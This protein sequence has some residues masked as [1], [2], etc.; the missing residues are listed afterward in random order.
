MLYID[1]VTFE[2]EILIPVHQI[3]VQNT[4]QKVSFS[5]SI[6]NTSIKNLLIQALRNVLFIDQRVQ[7]IG[8]HNGFCIFQSLSCE[9]TVPTYLLE[10]LKKHKRCLQK[11]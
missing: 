6:K 5:Q 2:N 3:F 7:T 11:P 9:N 1:T 10:E 8:C 4:R